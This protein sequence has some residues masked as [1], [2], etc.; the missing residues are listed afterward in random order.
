MDLKELKKK[1]QTNQESLSKAEWA[2]ICKEPFSV[3]KHV[4]EKSP[5]IIRKARKPTK[6]ES[7]WG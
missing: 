2:E 7:W 6:K 3:P 4:S 5:V 1:A